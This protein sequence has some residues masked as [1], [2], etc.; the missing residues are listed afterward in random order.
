MKNRD[1][2]HQIEPVIYAKDASKQ[3]EKR[4]AVWSYDTY[5]VLVDLPTVSHR[6]I[7]LRLACWDG[8]YSLLR[9]RADLPLV[10]LKFV[11]GTTALDV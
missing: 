8:Q 11:R 3:A 10:T 1:Q 5:P 9:L 7:V 6:V 4:V 2:V